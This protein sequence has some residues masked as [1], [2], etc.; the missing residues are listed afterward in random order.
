MCNRKKHVQRKAAEIEE[1]RK[2]EEAARLAKLTEKEEEQHRLQAE[3]KKEHEEVE[4]QRLERSAVEKEAAHLRE[5]QTAMMAHMQDKLVK[6]KKTNEKS[7]TEVKA[8]P[9]RAAIL[10]KTF[11]MPPPGSSADKRDRPIKNVGVDDYVT[12]LLGES[13]EGE[14][15]PRPIPQ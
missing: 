10:D 6:D 4:R 3:R 1:C 2:P 14:D 13:S 8:A 15:R 12:D 7:E 5:Q 11:D 9:N